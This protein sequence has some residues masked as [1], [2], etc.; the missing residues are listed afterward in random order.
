MEMQGVGISTSID[1]S[2]NNCLPSCGVT[3]GF[4]I[5]SIRT[6]EGRDQVQCPSPIV[7]REAMSPLAMVSA[8]FSPWPEHLLVLMIETIDIEPLAMSSSALSSVQV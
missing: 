1:S 5:Q 3:T 2:F 8:T 7:A 6:L 4:F